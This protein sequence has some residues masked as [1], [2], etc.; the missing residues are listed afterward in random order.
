MHDE[1]YRHCDYDHH[2]NITGRRWSLDGRGGMTASTFWTAGD[3]G[4]L[5]ERRGRLGWSHWV[6]PV[7]NYEYRSRRISVCFYRHNYFCYEEERE[8]FMAC[9]CIFAYVMCM[10][11]RTTSQYEHSRFVCPNS[12][13]M[14]MW[15]LRWSCSYAQ[16]TEHCVMKT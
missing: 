15:R 2:S 7:Y 10:Q 6:V 14:E 8:E 16:Q 3:I 4:T 9:M 1:Y 13:L 11:G 12:G 5:A